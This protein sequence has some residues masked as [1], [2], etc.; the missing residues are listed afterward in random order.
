MPSRPSEIQVRPAKQ[1]GG[2]ISV[3]GDK[4]I[5]HR[6]VMLAALTNGP[7]EISGFLPSEDCLST[8]GAMR[9]L[10]VKIDVLEEGLSGPTKLL[11]HGG[12]MQL[13]APGGPIDC[14]N[15]GTTMRL[16]SGIL[17]G[18]GFESRLIG[19]ES[20][21]RRP[22]NR[23]GD[24]LS[25][26]GADIDAEGPEGCAPLLI[27]GGGL[28]GMRYELPVASA[29]VKSAVLLAGL[30]A[31]GKTTVV[32]PVSTRDHT[33]RMLEYF[34]VKTVI[35]GDEISIYGGQQLESRD[36]SVPGDI[37]S[38]AFWVT[39]A[40]AMPG[41]SLTITDVGLNPT[42]S[43]ILQVLPQM[44]AHISDS[45][46]SE[47]AG[48]LRG[49]VAVQGRQLTGVEINGDIIPNIIDELPILAVA[50]AL[51]SGTTVIADAAELR[52]KETD[53]I[54]AV[55]G[56]LRAMGVDV[57]ET[58][59]GMI[60]RGGKPLRGARMDSYGDHRIA[61]A[62]AVAG[63]FADGETVITDADCVSISYPDFEADLKR[64][65]TAPKKAEEALTPVIT[66]VG[67]RAM[68]QGPDSQK[69]EL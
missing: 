36:F 12:G 2:E 38:A 27:R 34:Q 69:L 68:R 37:S 55:A 22:M 64:L 5:S 31:E 32:Q 26:M 16:M 29:Q 45:V 35:E 10:G 44:G 24:P 15:S 63:L 9:E 49:N 25:E 58:Y 3:P 67:E 53:R 59:D 13:K 33:E 46:N 52:V 61:M 42:R 6:S 1:L 7:C 8:V 20:L 62:F 66:S 28:T 30:F 21:S 18:Q 51:A 23:V 17:A 11:V 40:A 60:I 19:D 47:S 39:A 65:L 56:N 14:G 54:M 4:S 48:E 50:G 57:E 41:A 43:G